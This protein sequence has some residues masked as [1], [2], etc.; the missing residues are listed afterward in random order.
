MKLNIFTRP[1]WQLLVLIILLAFFLRLPNINANFAGDEIDIVGPA[2]SF[3]TT[4]DFRVFDDCN[5]YPYYNFTHPAVRTFLYSAWASIFGFSNIALRLLSTLLGLASIIVIY[6]FG[7]ELYS[8]KVGLVAAFIASVSRYHT[9]GSNL[10]NTDTGHFI[11]TTSITI[12][13]FIMYLKRNNKKY[14]LASLIFSILSMLTKFSTIIIFIPIL[15]GAYFYNKKKMGIFYVVLTILLSVFLLFGTSIIMNNSD[16]FEHPI[17]GFITYSQSSAPTLQE[18]FM[19]KVFKLATISWQM[20]P[21]FT[22]LLLVSIYS[23]YRTKRDKNFWI[24]SSWLVLGFLIIFMPYGQ[25]T[26]RFFLIL[27]TPAFIITAKFIEGLNFRNRVLP[28]VIIAILVI[29]VTINLN[30]LMGYYNPIYL[31][32]FYVIA[33]ISLFHKKRQSIILAGFIALSIFSAFYGNSISISSQAVG[34]L[35]SSIAAAG[36][37]YKEVWTSKDVAFYITPGNETVMN[38]PLELDINFIKDNNVKY[39]AFYSTVPRQ[40]NIKKI[41]ELCTE[42]SLIN[43]VN[44]NG[45]ICEVGK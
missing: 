43:V 12:L 5:G 16:M 44:N 45:F 25:D 31:G 17:R 13:F 10:V 6:L 38:C 41:M 11:F 37:P 27:L 26:Q 21:F 9:Y 18:Y 33:L 36:Y 40:D 2:R 32:L 4:G 3:V 28:L 8:E 42:S 24:V 23:L 39:L 15:T 1:N 30:D 20:T 35:S 19:N 22:L 34:E 7:K 29:A 14:F